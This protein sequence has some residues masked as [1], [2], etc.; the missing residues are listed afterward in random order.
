MNSKDYKSDLYWNIKTRHLS[1]DYQQASEDI[2]LYIGRSLKDLDIKDFEIISGYV[3][4]LSTKLYPDHHTWIEFYDGSIVDVCSNEML[5]IDSKD[6]TQRTELI[7]LLIGIIH[8]F[9]RFLP[10]GI[11]FFVYLSSALTKCIY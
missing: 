3:W 6:F 8:T 5:G 9:V 4:G 2:C 1:L 11:Y 10:L 7:N